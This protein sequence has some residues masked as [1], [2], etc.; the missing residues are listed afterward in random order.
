MILGGCLTSDLLTSRRVEGS[1]VV[2]EYIY[3]LPMLQDIG[4]GSFFMDHL[5]LYYRRLGIKSIL[6]FADAG[7]E[8]WYSRFGFEEVLACNAS[9]QNFYEEWGF[10]SCI[11]STLMQWLI[12]Y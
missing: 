5:R 3:V 12:P 7:K 1:F 2:I 8:G 4:Y 9:D 6:L 11:N 10:T